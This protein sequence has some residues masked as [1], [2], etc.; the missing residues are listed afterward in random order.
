MT[1]QKLLTD[2]AVRAKDKPPGYYLDGHG[3]YLQVSASGSR[4]WIFRYTLNKKTREMGMGSLDDFSLAEARERTRRYRQILADGHD[5]IEY[6]REEK[7]KLQASQLEANR[8]GIT[9]S[10]CAKEYH[11]TNK[12][13]W[14]N[15][16]HAAQWINTLSTYAFPK[17]GDLPVGEVTR[18]HMRAALLPIWKEKAETASRVLQRIRTVINHGAAMGYCDGLDSEAWDQLKK[19]LPKNS[20]Q[21]V[22]EHHASCPY[23]EVGALLLAVSRS[24]S[25]DV[26][27][28]AFAFIVLTA[29][30]SGEVRNA[31]WEEI[32]LDARC[33]T[34]P[35]ERMK[36]GREHT[37]PLSDAAVRVLQAA[38]KLRK[39]DAQPSG[40]IFKNLQ[41]HA[42]SDMTFTQLLRRMGYDFT[43]HGFRASFRTWGADIA[44]YEHEMLEV[45]LSHVVGDA[46]VR[47]YHRSD[48]VEKRRKLMD[49]W[50]AYLA[51][52][53]E[54]GESKSEEKA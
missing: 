27:K 32:D 53:A 47:A 29:A 3:L 34:I 39:S 26:V 4:S 31:V 6:R 12:D 2:P 51:Q 36:A 43:M 49:E 20:K 11:E 8:R 5:P 42:L 25:G 24:T 45:A 10:D 28:L 35:K 19:S 41:G 30:R 13:D 17:F 7:A 14:K 22:V 40:L 18:E 33:W 48:M 38:A 52:T 37:V 21:R 54:E 44:H 50:A 46:T 1:K 23:S 15:A 9:F 16:K